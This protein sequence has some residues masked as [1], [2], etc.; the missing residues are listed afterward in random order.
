MNVTP[1]LSPQLAAVVAA[2]ANLSAAI[3]ALVA[4]TGPA[5]VSAI[6][7]SVLA[8]PEVAALCAFPAG[9]VLNVQDFGAIGDGKADDTVAIGKAIAAASG[10]SIIYFPSGFYAVCNQQPGTGPIFDLTGKSDLAFV[11][12]HVGVSV[13]VGYMQGLADPVL[14][15][16]VIGGPTDYFKIGRF[17]MFKMFAPVQRI[18]FRSLVID[19]Q[20]PSTG[21]G[22]V[23][24]VIATGDGWDMTHKCFQMDGT[25][26]IDNI[27]I[28]NCLLRNWRGEIVYVGGNT[29]RAVSVVLTT[30]K[31]CNASAISAGADMLVNNCKIGGPG[32]GEAVYNGFENQCMQAPQKLVI[33]K[34]EMQNAWANGIVYSGAPDCSLLLEDSNVHDCGRGLLLAEQ[35]A[36]LIVRRNTFKNAQIITSV[37]SGGAG[38][39]GASITDNTLDNSPVVLQAGIASLVLSR[40]TVLNGPLCVNS[41]LRT[42]SIIDGNILGAGGVDAV[43][44]YPDQLGLWSNTQRPDT[45]SPWPSVG[46]RVNDYSG[47]KAMVI[48]PCTDV[49]FINDNVTSGPIMLTIDPTGYQVGFTTLLR[50]GKPNWVLQKGAWNTFPADTPVTD[51]LKIRVN[52][53]QLFELVS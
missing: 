11:G 23:G 27:L 37:I 50:V 6:D 43:S 30:I 22:T 45:A 4:S 15:W 8:P 29:P 12:D 46:Y 16:D 32:K 47:A 9:T 10:P 13:L 24:G 52:A 28:F 3:D 35:G 2:S 19:G 48:R 51:G 17:S 53:Q 25:G 21:D 20:C 18:Q 44:N 36:D 7:D 41:Y 31:G 1:N 42:D 33:Q 5:I 38:F 40:N 34:T 49:S 39:E 26:V 14:H